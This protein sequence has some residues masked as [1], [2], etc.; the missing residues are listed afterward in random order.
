MINFTDIMNFMTMATN[1]LV[2]FSENYFIKYYPKEI[3]Y[4]SDTEISDA[5]YEETNSGEAF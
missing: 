3:Q 5:L 4:V 1:D 2:C